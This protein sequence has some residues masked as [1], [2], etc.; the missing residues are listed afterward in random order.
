MT[1]WGTPTS[2]APNMT[3]SGTGTPT[4]WASNMTIS[5]T[6]LPGSNGTDNSSTWGPPISYTGTIGTDWSITINTQTNWTEAQPTGIVAGSDTGVG[7]SNGTL[8]AAR[9][10]RG[11]NVIPF[12]PAVTTATP[13]PGLFKRY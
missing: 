13:R 12:Y 1:T 5:G 8:I 6:G 9:T 3:I 7:T 2:W 11:P 10:P 4:P